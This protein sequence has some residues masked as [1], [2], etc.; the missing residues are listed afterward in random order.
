MR[1][2]DLRRTPNLLMGGGGTRDLD[3]EIPGR[4]LAKAHSPQPRLTDNKS[5]TAWGSKRPRVLPCRLL[6]TWCTPLGRL[7]IWGALGEGSIRRHTRPRLMALHGLGGGSFTRLLP[8][9][10]LTLAGS[11]RGSLT[12]RTPPPH[13][14]R[15]SDLGDLP[16]E[17]LE[18]P[19]FGV[20]GGL[21][22][23]FLIVRRC[24]RRASHK[25]QTSRTHADVTRN[26]GGNPRTRTHPYLAI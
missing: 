24:R 4:R 11:G 13:T 12:R 5:G 19:T 16:P 10:R 2:L 8:P 17:A 1:S 14:S 23:P 26:R 7:P 25:R 18:A 15:H 9:P 21:I 3:N 6:A 20:P 22:P